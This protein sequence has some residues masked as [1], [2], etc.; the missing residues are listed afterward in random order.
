MELISFFLTHWK[1]NEDCELQAR[2]GPD[3]LPKQRL[4]PIPL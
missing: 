2:R 1:Q 4:F 3:V